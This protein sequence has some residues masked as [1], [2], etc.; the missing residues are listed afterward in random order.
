MQWMAA[1]AAYQ[2]ELARM[3]PHV[4]M[5]PAILPD[6]KSWC[7]LYGEDLVRGVA[8]FGDTPEQACEDFD[9]NWRT[10]RQKIGGNAHKPK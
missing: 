2:A 10:L 5:R 7:A 4:L 3:R 9:R 1:D 6:G 8:G